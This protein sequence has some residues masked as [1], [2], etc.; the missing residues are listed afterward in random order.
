MIK[1]K[2]YKKGILI[3]V[4][5][6]LWKLARTGDKTIDFDELDYYIENG[7]LYYKEKPVIPHIGFVD[8][9]LGRSS[10][11]PIQ[12]IQDRTPYLRLIIGD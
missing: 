2:A 5:N 9:P 10:A 6:N 8:L 3:D 4:E 7:V 11:N 1:V 12:K